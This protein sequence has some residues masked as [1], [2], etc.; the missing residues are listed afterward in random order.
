[1]DKTKNRFFVALLPPQEIQDYV[2]EIKQHFASVYASCGALKSPSHITLQPPFEWS[3]E[4]VPSL[5]ESLKTF[6]LRHS[7][8]PIILSGF[9][10]FPPRVI[11]INVIKTPEL[12]ALQAD[13]RAYLEENLGIVDLSQKRSFAPHMTIAFR[14]LTRHK[15]YASW[16]EYQHRTLDFKFTAS[17]LTLLIYTGQRW[18][19]HSSLPFL[20]ALF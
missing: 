1:M 7:P 19:I 15:F 5:E 6:A 18:N 12:M 20:S 9:G 13:L 14:D 16:P 3:V 17:H 2:T 8:I 4:A 11:Y 10:A